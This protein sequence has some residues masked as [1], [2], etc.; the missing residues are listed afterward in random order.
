MVLLILAGLLAV[1]LPLVL[2]EVQ[3]TA[4]APPPNLRPTQAPQDVRSLSIDFGIV[5]D[6]DTDWPGVDAHLDASGATTVNLNAGRTEFTAFDWPE[7]PGAAAEPGTDHLSVAARAVRT[8]ADGAARPVNL[9]VD[10]YLPEWIR[11]DPSIAGVDVH[12]RRSQYT[13]S[14]AQFADGAVGD[15]LLAYAA[16][17]GERYDPNQIEITEL[18]LD[19][20]TFGDDDFALFRRMT[21]EADWPRTDKGAIDTDAPLIGVWRS[22]VLAGLM[23]RIRTALDTVRDGQG[24]DIGLVLDVRVD[25]TDPAG[26]RPLSG[27][28]Y[29][30]LLRTGIDLQLW[31]YVGRADKTPSQVQV[32]TGALAAGGYDMSRFI[33]SIGL[34][35]GDAAADP[36][37]R[38]TPAVLAEA[39][40]DAATNRI[41]AVNVTPYSLM[42]EAHWSAL[43]SVWT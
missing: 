2:R 8:T 18:F 28:D 22:E 12:G 4:E 19:T 42:T 33:V 25:W 31:V 7:H 5:T 37:G 24:R 41:S 15:R 16:A 34:W 23:K 17:L 6:P 36:P 9:I 13:A 38:I 27:H 14:A 11:A 43:A 39:V 40:T 29:T 26:G 35:A 1:T 3:D 32:L 30:I 20:F 21:G 10:A